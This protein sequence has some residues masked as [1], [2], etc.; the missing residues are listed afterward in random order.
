MY[1]KFKNLF[2]FCPIL[3][4]L[5]NIRL[6]ILNLQSVLK[7]TLSFTQ[8][9]QEPR[10]NLDRYESFNWHDVKCKR[11]KFSGLQG[12]LGGFVF[13]PSDILSYSP[14]KPIQLQQQMFLTQ[15]T[16]S[17]QKGLAKL[18]LGQTGSCRY[19]FCAI[20][21]ICALK[22]SSTSC[23]Q[24]TNGSDSGRRAAPP[25]KRQKWSKT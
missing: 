10:H 14:V 23:T 19:T 16:L 24:P 22:S 5:E 21:E 7:E 17:H 11:S 1:S 12:G 4:L 13:R 15:S 6:F 9:I 8:Q 25:Q 18:W 20:C 3:C 2:S